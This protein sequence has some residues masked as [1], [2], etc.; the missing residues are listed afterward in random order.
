M[1]TAA[2]FATEQTPGAVARVERSRPRHENTSASKTR[3]IGHSS[4]AAASIAS[5]LLIRPS[6]KTSGPE[7]LQRFHVLLWHAHQRVAKPVGSIRATLLLR[8]GG[9]FSPHAPAADARTAEMTSIVRSCGM[10]TTGD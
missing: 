4:D 5:A 7:A 3:A 1:D 2:Y 8:S 6:P 10:V 9:T